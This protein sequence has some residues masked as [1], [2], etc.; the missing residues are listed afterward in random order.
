MNRHFQ[1]KLAKSR[2]KHNIETT[3]SIPTKFCTMI[4]TTKPPNARRGWS[5]RTHNKSKMADGCHIEKN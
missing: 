1:A 3:A 5:K 2:N 4:K